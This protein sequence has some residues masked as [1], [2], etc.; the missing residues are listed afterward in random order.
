MNVLWKIH[1]GRKSRVEFCP[2]TGDSYNGCT[3]FQS[4][5]HTPYMRVVASSFER[6]LYAFREYGSTDSASH[7]KR[8]HIGHRNVLSF[9][10]YSLHEL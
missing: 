5:L 1:N 7:C 10:G 6:I 3:L 2:G 8:T 4:S 9:R